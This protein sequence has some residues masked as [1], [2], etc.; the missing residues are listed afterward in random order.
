MKDEFFISRDVGVVQH[1]WLFERLKETY[2][3]KWLSEPQLVGALFESEC[4]SL[5]RRIEGKPS[6]QIGFARAVTD[7]CTFSSVMDVYIETG[8]RNKGLGTMLM[9]AVMKDPAIAKTI[10]VISTKDAHRFYR[11][12]GFTNVSAMKHDPQP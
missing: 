3:G 9:N 2:W 12:F 1:H 11:K 7:K 5:F 10:C 8:Y 6:V 4:F